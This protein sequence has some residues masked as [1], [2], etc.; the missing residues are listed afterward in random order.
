[1]LAHQMAL[2]LLPI[3]GGTWNRSLSSEWLRSGPQKPICAWTV[4]SLFES[5]SMHMECS[6]QRAQYLGIR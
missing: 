1:M 5:L 3:V 2:A 6:D 4:M